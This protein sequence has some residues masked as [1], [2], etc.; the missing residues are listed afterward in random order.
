MLDL[1]LIRVYNATRL[2]CLHLVTSLC[3]SLRADN[4]IPLTQRLFAIII[5]AGDCQDD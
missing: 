4:K 2:L 5:V 1:I 3:T